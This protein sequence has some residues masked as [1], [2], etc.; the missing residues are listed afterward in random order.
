MNHNYPG[1]TTAHGLAGVC[2]VLLVAGF[3]PAQES[4][5]KYQPNWESLDGY[6][7][8]EWFDDAKFGIFIH[9][10]GY[11]QFGYRKNNRGY[12]E[13]VPKMI[14]EDPDHY[15]PVLKERF[16]GC[17]PEFG[18]KD[19]LRQ[20]KAEKFDPD[21]WASL[22]DNAGAK[23][24]VLTAEH[25][26]GFAL[27]DSELT[28][29]C[30]TKVGPMRDLVGDLGASVRKR[31]LKYAP[32][33][34][35]ERH[36]GF[37]AVEKYAVHSKPRPDIRE[38]IRRV[39][40]A[41]G[42]YGP[43]S[44]TDEFIADYVARWQEIQ[45]KYR[46]DFMWIDDIPIFTRAAGDPQVTKFQQACAAMIADY[47]NAADRWGVD[48]YLNNKG[49]NPNWPGDLGCLEKD[50]LQMDSIKVKWENPAT[51]ATSYGYM[52]AEEQNDLYQSSEKLIHLLCDVVSK[53]GNLLL[54]IGPRGDG[55]IPDGMQQRLLGM[56][57][58][59][60]VNGEAIYGSRPWKTY[61][62]GI[63]ETS[64]KRDKQGRHTINSTGIRFTRS[65]HETTV[66]AILFEPSEDPLEIKSFQGESVSKV[67]L[68]GSETPVAWKLAEGGLQI[69]LPPARPCEGACVLKVGLK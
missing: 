34:H 54:N 48:V 47:F 25:H 22:F 56:G 57:R 46:P 39:P 10:G 45:R 50:N 28:E 58:W 6:P 3:S 13:H 20:F 21:R 5:P 26:D 40:E 2:L 35:R 55:V 24:V 29:W 69:T 32:S 42:L 38:E 23:Y 62:E 66:Y 53:N 27:W 18:Y 63:V 8:P 64:A 52:A 36:T 44:Y 60:D 4:A 33:Y 14:Y 31:G 12:A 59:L 51:L 37:Y 49:S 61:G 16:G 68:L 19:M 43:F 11:S 67:Q 17:P 15:Y 7:V 1:P 30:A 9:W 41:E 65:K